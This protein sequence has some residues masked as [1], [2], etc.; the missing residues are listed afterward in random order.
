MYQTNTTDTASCAHA[1]V[2][3]CT[4]MQGVS[5]RGMALVIRT[6]Y[7]ATYMKVTILWHVQAKPM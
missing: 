2:R 5:P 3:M 7:S 1:I 4:R 6:K